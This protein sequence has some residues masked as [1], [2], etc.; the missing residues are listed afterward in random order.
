M[1]VATDALI[2]LRDGPTVPESVVAWMLNAED[3]GLR[4]RLEPDGRLHVGPSQAIRTDDDRFI[5][6]H[7]DVL[8]ACV[9]YIDATPGA[10]M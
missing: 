8:L 7:R 3:R 1:A 2:T 5:R 9:R 10:V 6:E 4:F